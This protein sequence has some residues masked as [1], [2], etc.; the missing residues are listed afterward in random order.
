VAGLFLDR[1]NQNKNKRL[2]AFAARPGHE[3]IGV[4]KET[5]S[6]AKLDRAERKKVMTLA[7]RREI[8]IVLVRTATQIRL[9]CCKIRTDH[10]Q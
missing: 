2:T 1:G 3:V 9:L 8:D 4:F 7:Q 10:S 5:D 6:G